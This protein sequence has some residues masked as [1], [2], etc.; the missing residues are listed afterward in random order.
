MAQ[1]MEGNVL[2][3]DVLN[4][5]FMVTWY[6]VKVHSEGNQPLP[7]HGLLFLN[8]NNGSF[9]C[10]IPHKVVHTMAF[11]TP[12]VEHW[13]NCIWKEG[14]G[15]F[16]DALIL[17]MVTWSQ[18]YG[19]VPLDSERGNPVLPHGLLFLINSKGSFICIIP[20]TG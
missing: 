6:W 19:K 5:L 9:I 3:N 17:F 10:A 7:L 20:K 13:L 14:S 8:C 18:I 2:F 15:F 11:V 4:M 16:N 12:V 1:R